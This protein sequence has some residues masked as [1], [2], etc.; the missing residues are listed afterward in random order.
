M[1]AITYK[2]VL[3]RECK[4]HTARYVVSARCAALSNGKWG[5]GVPHP[6]LDGVGVGGVRHPVLQVEGVP[7]PVLD[8][9]GYPSIL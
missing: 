8:G 7:H 4:R 2:K 3:L 1:I 9:D 5:G 6:V